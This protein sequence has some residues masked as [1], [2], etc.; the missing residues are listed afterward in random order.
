MLILYKNSVSCARVFHERI[1]NSGLSPRE[2]IRKPPL[3]RLPLR[4]IPPAAV[5]D[6]GIFRTIKK[7]ACALFFVYRFSS[8]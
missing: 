6:G 2:K 1:V 3:R 4:D 5:P 8:P 7:R